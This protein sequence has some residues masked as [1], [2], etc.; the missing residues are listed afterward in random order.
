MSPSITPYLVIDGAAAA[1][2]WYRNVLGAEEISRMTGG[3]GRIAHAEIRIGGSPIFIGDEHVHY[4]DIHGPMR[5]GGSPVYLDLETDDVAGAFERAVA[6]G[7][8]PIRQPTDPSMPIQSAKFRDPFGHI[9]LL[10][11]VVAD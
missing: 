4:E 8:T 9:W 7:A 1:I 10:T 6:A 11:R 5:V 2:D 3:A